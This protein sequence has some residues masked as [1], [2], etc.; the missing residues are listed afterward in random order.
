M[1][2]SLSF[3]TLSVLLSDLR[4][5]KIQMN[6]PLLTITALAGELQVEQGSG[7]HEHQGEDA[8]DAIHEDA[9]HRARAPPTLLRRVERLDHVAARGTGDHEVEEA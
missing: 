3:V 4:N 6:F 1:T 5:L 2:T 9:E 7:G 8:D